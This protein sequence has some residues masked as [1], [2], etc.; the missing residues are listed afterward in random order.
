MDALIHATVATPRDPQATHRQHFYSTVLPS[1]TRRNLLK[2][3]DGAPFYP[4]QKPKRVILTVRLDNA[5]IR[6][7]RYSFALGF[8]SGLHR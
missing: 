7:I 1:R 2:T 5:E 3:N 8:R 4:S 6:H